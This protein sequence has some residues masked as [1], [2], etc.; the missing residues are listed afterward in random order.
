MTDAAYVRETTMVG[1]GVVTVQEINA[2]G[3]DAVR[4]MDAAL[5]TTDR[6]TTPTLNTGVATMVGAGVMTPN[7]M[8]PARTVS[9][10]VWTVG[11]RMTTLREITETATLALA[12]TVGT[13]VTTE[14]LINDA[15]MLA[16]VTMDGGGMTAVLAMS[17]AAIDALLVIEGSGVTTDLAMS[18]TPMDALVVINGVGV[19][20]V[21]EM[22]LTPME[23]L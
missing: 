22:T 11:A 14:R 20:T 23:A 12:E 15:V 4:V 5:I 7:A 6:D 21:R 17:V 10:A 9:A 8:R 2:A 13:Y 1:I 3:I 18:D 16:V 19:T